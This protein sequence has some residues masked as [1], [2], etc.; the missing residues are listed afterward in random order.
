MFPCS[1]KVVL[2]C[3]SAATSVGACFSA[4][5]SCVDA[6]L[7]LHL[8]K[9]KHSRL[10]FSK[11]WSLDVASVSEA[12]LD[13]KTSRAAAVF[14]EASSSA[15][16]S[17]CHNSSLALNLNASS[18][19][20]FMAACRSSVAAFSCSLSS[21]AACVATCNLDS[22]CCSFSAKAASSMLNTWVWNA[23]RWATG[24]LKVLGK[25]S[26]SDSSIAHLA[27]AASKSTVH[28]GA[29]TA[30]KLSSFKAVKAVLP[31]STSEWSSS[32]SL[33][34]SVF[35]DISS[36]TLSNASRFVAKPS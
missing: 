30:S 12:S 13:D 9:A 36:L 35:L 4:L 23:A 33:T 11:S 24:L 27:I 6:L 3:P 2:D 10:I 29:G 7:T 31:A 15:F 18:F 8:S 1:S 26:R 22:T 34:A 25:A 28:F 16:R 17:L 5:A 19:S 32:N 20:A 14:A 21:S